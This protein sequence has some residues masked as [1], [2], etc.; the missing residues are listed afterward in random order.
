MVTMDSTD[1]TTTA[2]GWYDDST[3]TSITY[4]CYKDDRDYEPEYLFDE[5]E[6]VRSGWYNPRK[7]NLPVVHIV[8]RIPIQ[9][10]NQLPHKMRES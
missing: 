1:S 7:I 3:A 9:I 2:T 8:P 6:A 10:R 5:I 4:T